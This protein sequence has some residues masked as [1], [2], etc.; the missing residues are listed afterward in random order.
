MF[1]AAGAV[2]AA[3]EEAAAEATE[4]LVLAVEGC[5]QAGMAPEAVRHAVEFRLDTC[6]A[7][8]LDVEDES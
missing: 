2:E 5:V 1:V 8:A 6:R 4:R 7:G 3:R